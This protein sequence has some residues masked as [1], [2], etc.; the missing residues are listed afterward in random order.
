MKG[1]AWNEVAVCKNATATPIECVSFLVYCLKCETALK[2]L[3]IQ[4]H[5]RNKTKQTEK[6]NETT[7]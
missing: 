3:E 6:Y 5:K 1:E 2:L 7:H 4:G